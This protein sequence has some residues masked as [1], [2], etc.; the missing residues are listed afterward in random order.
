[1]PLRPQE[2]LAMANVTQIYISDGD[3]PMG[4]HLEQ[5]VASVKRHF[6][7]SDHAVFTNEQIVR[8]L[9]SHYPEEVSRAYEV[10]IPYAYKADL[11]RLCLVNV[12]GGWYLDFVDRCHVGIEVPENVGFVVFRDIPRYS[13]TSWPLSNS[14]FY[15]R[16]QNPVLRSVYPDDR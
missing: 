3:G 13:Q 9:S 2:S 5:C 8:F 15:S 7:G 16:P 14:V 6:P 10:L 11:A 12:L 1:M 4:Q